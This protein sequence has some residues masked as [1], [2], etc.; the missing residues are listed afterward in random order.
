M[1]FRGV[2]AAF[3]VILIGIFFYIYSVHKSLEVAQALCPKQQAV[4]Q[5]EFALVD[6]I[7]LGQERQ[8]LYISKL[9]K[10]SPL[11]HLGF[12]QG[13]I[14][15][16]VSDQSILCELSLETSK[17]LFLRVA[18]LGLDAYSES[19][20]KVLKTPAQFLKKIDN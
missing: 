11:R 12:D 18:P 1:R 8:Y 13:D 20:W 15:R 19:D 17:N 9:A 4:L 6:I 14:F 7:D 16:G 2:I 5:A 10:N 3:I